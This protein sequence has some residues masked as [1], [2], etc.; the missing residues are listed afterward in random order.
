MSLDLVFEIGC[1]EIPHDLLDEGI[2]GLRTAL[3][4]ALS[5]A[6]LDPSGDF[7]C[8]GTPRRLTVIARRI[9]DTQPTV[10]ETVT[11]PPDGAARD[12]D[13]HY[14]KAADG[15]AKK[16]GVTTADLI[17]VDTERGRYLAVRKTVGGMATADLMASL[18][19]QVLGEIHWAKA[20][21]W[22][23]DQGPFVR[24]IKW[25]CAV[26]G[27]KT[28][29]FAFAGVTAG[30]TS[31]GHRFM[32]PRAFTVNGPDDYR[33]K[34]AAA[35]VLLHRAERRERIRTQVAQQ[36]TMAGGLPREDA[37]LVAVTALKTEWPVAV[38]GKF[39]PA[40][41]EL[42]PQVLLTSMKEHQDD[43]GVER[44]GTLIPCFVAVA[45][46]EATDM[47][48]VA[49]GNERVLRARLEDARF[50]YREDRKHRL[51]ALLPRL[52]SFMF[53]KDLGSVGDKARRVTALTRSLAPLLGA[54][55]DHAAR[56]AELCKA[57]LVSNMVF[58][59]PELQGIMGRAYALADG[60]PAAAADAIAAHYLPRFAG[61][62]LPS[63]AE[64]RAVAIA[65]KVDTLAGIFGV[66]LV[67]SGSQDPYALRRQ[68][69]GVALMLADAPSG[70]RLGGLV[71]EAV[72]QLA[73]RLTRPAAE[74]AAEVAAFLAQRLA[75][76]LEQDGLRPDV[77]KATLAGACDDAHDARQR[78]HALDAL[79]T[80]A[81][82]DDLMT[83]FKRVIKIIPDGFAPS[84][85]AA[86][87]LK[88]GPE[89]D[90]WRAFRAAREQMG[91]DR[92][93]RD[94]LAAMAALRPRVDAF[95]DGVMVMDADPAVRQDRLSML[96]AI[97]DTFRAF[98]DFSQVAAP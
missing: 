1:E 11:G 94:R 16:Q 90:L 49:H 46:N 80:E 62:A 58:E 48:L 43:F 17:T 66:G 79:T 86:E 21:R 74:V 10:E 93:A 2:A 67:P 50:F 72:E 35:K 28:V 40:Y 71:S 8:E 92:P 63:T 20:M 44:N 84:A 25:I 51:E 59:F 33:E 32:A 14:T 24:P 19:P 56:A 7:I 98:A 57:D 87:R 54:N 78:A 88:P 39:D 77:V 53:Q 69:L 4:R 38:L 34:L 65:D 18:L 12:K 52:D 70:V 29:D 97:R 31:R 60:E 15:F 23:T 6:R 3:A 55:A 76:G 9:P 45:D 68:G 27:G 96:A 85:V 37:E 41:L 75:Y 26:L 61:D 91:S 36:A 5:A 89:A 82:F 47:A 83:S 64:G 22:G 81:G 95:F 13:G 42:P 30:N 73:G